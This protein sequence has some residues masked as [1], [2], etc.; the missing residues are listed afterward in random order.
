VYGQIGVCFV[1]PTRSEGFS[2]SRVGTTGLK[3]LLKVLR[4]DESGRKQHSEYNS[5]LH[6]GQTQALDIEGTGFL[7]E[8]LHSAHKCGNKRNDY[9]GRDP[10]PQRTK[11]QHKFTVDPKQQGPVKL[12]IFSDTCGNLIQMYQPPQE[13]P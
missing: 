1:L 6:L 12:A 9:E 7:K 5:V 11:S 2:G 13:R 10:S 3:M 8:P 4:E